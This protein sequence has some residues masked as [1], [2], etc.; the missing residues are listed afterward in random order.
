VA[1]PDV[2]V[3]K[4]GISDPERMAIAESAITKIRTAELLARPV[5][6]QFDAEHLRAIHRRLMGDIYPHAGEYRPS[7]RGWGKLRVLSDGRRYAVAYLP[8]GDLGRRID[9]VSKDAALSLRQRSP[10]DTRGIAEDAAKVYSAIDG[11]HPFV[12]GNS[13]TL[14]IFTAQLVK[15][16][17]GRDL[18]WGPTIV[19]NK[20]RDEVYLARDRAVVPE[21]MKFTTDERGLMALSLASDVVRHARP[22]AAIIGEG[23]VVARA[24]EQAALQERPA[25]TLAERLSIEVRVRQQLA[26][27]RGSTLDRPNPAFEVFEQ[28]IRAE[29]GGK[30]LSGPDADRR[31]AAAIENRRH[32]FLEA[33]LAAR[34]GDGK[35][36]GRG[37]EALRRAVESGGPPIEGVSTPIAVK[38]ATLDAT[39]LSEIRTDQ[40]QLMAGLQVASNMRV[41]A[42]YALAMRAIDPRVALAIQEH[43]HEFETATHRPGERPSSSL[44]IAKQSPER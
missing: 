19:T 25:A 39:Q 31:R 29:E 43:G 38:W 16:T 8:F 35:R 36:A 12:D 44:P 15:E 21:A 14:R 5:R 3:N 7:S 22:L 13:R 20:A 33:A 23:L 42:E 4:L 30:P 9:D 6:G 37:T 11:V 24:K 41:S 28:R 10:D 26:Q 17:T 2:P 1:V 18:D 34:G 40:H 32:L 27:N